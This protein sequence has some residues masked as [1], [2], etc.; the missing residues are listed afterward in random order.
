M[1]NLRYAISL[2]VMLAVLSFTLSVFFPQPSKILK[3][4]RRDFDRGKYQAAREKFTKA[5]DLSKA[6]SGVRCEAQ[7]FFATCFVRENDLAKGARQLEEFIRLYPTSFW[8]PQAYFDLAYCE[9]ML[10]KREAAKQIYRM[11]I[12][13]FSTTSW[14]KYSK[15][16]LAEFKE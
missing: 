8:T 5:I 14:A 12:K 9:S 11:I 4:G 15:E 16:K 7:I 6:S 2:A 13:D 10:S 1:P 3:N